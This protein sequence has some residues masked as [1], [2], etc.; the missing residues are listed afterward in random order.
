MKSVRRRVRPARRV[1][2]H[3]PGADAAAVR[4]RLPHA[5]L[6]PACPSAKGGKP[7]RFKRKSA[8]LMRSL[9][10]SCSRAAV[11]M[12]VGSSALLPP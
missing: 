11:A 5:P 8:T 1:H 10:A 3:R 7:R 12:A 9:R 4:K 2:G 6:T